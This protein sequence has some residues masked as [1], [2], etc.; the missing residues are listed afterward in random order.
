MRFFFVCFTKCFC[1]FNLSFAF[2][3]HMCNGQTLL[4]SSCLHRNTIKSTFFKNALTLHFFFIPPCII[5]LFENCL[6]VT[7][8]NRQFES[9]TCWFSISNTS[10][11][12]SDLNF[13]IYDFFWFLLVNIQSSVFL[14]QITKQIWD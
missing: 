4:S 12:E 6:Y 7:V 13:V 14:L 9:Q 3:E 1:S 8:W 2:L 11:W 10:V 5:Q